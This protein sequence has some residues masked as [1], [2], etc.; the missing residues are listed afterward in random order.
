MKSSRTKTA[1]QIHSFM[2]VFG[3][4]FCMFV[5]ASLIDEN[6]SERTTKSEIKTIPIIATI[7]KEK[8]K[9]NGR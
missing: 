5:S 6:E 7:N 8:D 3:A 9:K 4:A 1:A 2:L